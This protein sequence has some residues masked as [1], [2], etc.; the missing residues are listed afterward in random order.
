MVHGPMEGPSSL[1]ASASNS[2]DAGKTSVIGSVRVTTRSI[3]PSAFVVK[4]LMPIGFVAVLWLLPIDSTLV[5]AS[6]TPSPRPAN[7]ASG[8]ITA[9]A[10]SRPPSPPPFSLPSA[11][12]PNDSVTPGA[13]GGGGGSPG[14]GGGGGGGGEI[15]CNTI[16]PIGVSITSGFVLLGD[17]LAAAPSSASERNEPTSL[18]V[19]SAPPGV[20][21]TALEL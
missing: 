8:S 15:R 11:P 2:A 19:T 14:A 7:N 1:L 5:P 6:T 10:L 9:T 12:P 18:S 17:I 16:L 3:D 20:R 21:R 4:R 13:R